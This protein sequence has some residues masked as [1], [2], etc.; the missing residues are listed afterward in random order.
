MKFLFNCF[1]FLVLLP[2]TSSGYFPGDERFEQMEREKEQQRLINRGRCYLEFQKVYEDYDIV[3][4]VEIEEH[5][6]RDY[7]FTDFRYK[8][9]KKKSQDK[10]KCVKLRSRIEQGSKVGS[11]DFLKSK[12]K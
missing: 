8:I 4:V 3:D 12:F 7:Y 2:L 1:I 5:H 10:K 9:H 6:H 11:C